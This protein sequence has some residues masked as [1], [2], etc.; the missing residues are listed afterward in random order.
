MPSI[1]DMPRSRS[2][3]P[4]VREMP[5]EKTPPPPTG[6]VVT[7]ETL[8]RPMADKMPLLC[9]KPLRAMRRRPLS[10]R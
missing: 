10:S 6:V 7:V 2:V 1:L 3:P 5:T 9:E 8:V 4:V